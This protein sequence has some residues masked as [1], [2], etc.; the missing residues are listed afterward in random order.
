MISF[1]FNVNLDAEG[2]RFRNVD[3]LFASKM[4][5]KCSSHHYTFL[6]ELASLVKVFIGT[7][8]LLSLIK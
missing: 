5:T 2:S 1:A 3:L 7:A 6:M 4:G 8:S